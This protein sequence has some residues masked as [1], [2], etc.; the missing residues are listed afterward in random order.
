VRIAIVSHVN[1]RVGGVESYLEAVVP[2]LRR[3]H[4]VAC[5]FESDTVTDQPLFVGAQEFP[6]WSGDARALRAWAPDVLFVHGLRSPAIE[7]ELLDIAPAVHFAHSYYGTCISGLKSHRWPADVICTRSFGPACAAYYFPRR[8][9]GLSPLTMV[10]QYR[11]QRSRLEVLRRYRRIV[12]ASAHMAAEYRQHGLARVQVVGLPVQPA[13]VV[14]HRRP[15]P[16]WKLLYLGRY[17]HNKGS[18]IALA[19]SAEAARVLGSPVHLSMAGAG[20]Q[21][22]M[23]REDAARLM[24]ES[25]WLTVS[26]SDWI[27]PAERDE[28]LASVDLL[29][30]PSRWPEPFGLVGL[31]AGVHGV[32]AVAF[33]AGGIRDWLSD[34]LNGRIVPGPPDVSRFAAALVEVLGNGSALVAMHA[35]AATSAARF[36]LESHVAHLEEA[37]CR[38]LSDPE[39]VA[40]A[41]AE[42]VR[43]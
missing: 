21:A 22:G 43:G 4:A 15:G 13:P 3:R 32:P 36:T 34:G 27:G 11:L 30:V 31:E 9:G 37:F 2:A 26:I 14:S 10:K 12:V 6:V 23:L 42:V 39:A 16:P 5:W 35:A 7:R 24:A 33:D 41:R 19:A 40:P 25:R 8:C 1:G 28:A 38:A 20:S 17:E 18:D 29:L